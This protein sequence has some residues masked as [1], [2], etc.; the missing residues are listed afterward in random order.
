LGSAG[1]WSQ[2]NIETFPNEL[3]IFKVLQLKA[4]TKV[5]LADSV[6]SLE[7]E[8]SVVQQLTL[9]LQPKHSTKV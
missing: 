1:A 5:D 7:Q 2:T 3:V 4:S 9:E 8:V 6:D